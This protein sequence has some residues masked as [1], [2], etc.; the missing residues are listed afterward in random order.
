MDHRPVVVSFLAGLLLLVIIRKDPRGVADRI[1]VSRFA[2]LCECN[3]VWLE[4][5]QIMWP[6]ELSW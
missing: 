5:Q 1:K 4:S 2:C 3:P 6:L